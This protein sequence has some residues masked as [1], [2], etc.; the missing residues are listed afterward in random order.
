MNAPT[1]ELLESR[2]APATLLP[3]GKA[4]T[5]TDTDGDLVTVKFS[6]P[7]LTAANVDTL[8]KF[9]TPFATSG[10]QHLN[11]LDLVS[12]PTS[13]NGLNLTVTAKVSPA[14]GNGEVDIGALNGSDVNLVTGMGPGID[15]GKVSIQGSLNFID[16]GDGD[17]NTLA[18]KSLN[19]IR[20]GAETPGIASDIHGSIG[21]VKIRDTMQGFL[22]LSSGIFTNSSQ[23]S[24]DTFIIGGSLAGGENLN[25]GSIEAREINL[26]RIGGNMIGGEGEN[27]GRIAVTSIHQLTVNGSI[28]GGPGTNSARVQGND[29][30]S[31]V[32]RG[33]IVGGT[34]YASAA[35]S[36]AT[37]TSLRIGRDLVG[38][39]G[40]FSGDCNPGFLQ[41]GS[42]GGNVVGGSGIGSGRILSN[43]MGTV[44]IGGSVLG[45]S[46]IASGTIS[47]NTIDVVRIKGD[48]VGGGGDGTGRVF[49]GG[50]IRA[51]GGSILGRIP[52]SG[53]V[54][55][56]AG[57]YASIF[58]IDIIT[59][60]R[61]LIAA[62]IAVGVTSGPDNQFGTVDD[63]TFGPN[64]RAR[65]GLLTIKGHVAGPAIAAS[66]GIEANA[67][68]TLRVGGVTFVDGVNGVDF[69]TGFLLDPQGTVKVRVIP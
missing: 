33:S 63:I 28:F 12:L 1:I 64:D 38:G 25:S 4:V 45:G 62:N 34:G 58:D 48:L 41:K 29:C 43:D 49:G 46:G 39:E 6:Q 24:I 23:L 37:L 7:I 69:A 65:I 51:I 32:V 36:V 26:L 68:G 9:D 16:A 55:S 18:L 42:I 67:I 56:A 50:H 13:A 53:D 66:F 10:P 44:L 14:G 19:V 35:I 57:L 21:S 40:D 27:S 30:D 31:V 5:F 61:D 11:F 2:I 8:F 20:L 15:L 52:D 60:G 3:G 22:R 59:I 17:L 47:A 54:S